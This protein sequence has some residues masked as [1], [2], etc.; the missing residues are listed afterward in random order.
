MITH[1]LK[2]CGDVERKK[3]R[4]WRGESERDG[5]AGR[6]REGG[7]ERGEARWREGVKR[8]GIGRGLRDGEKVV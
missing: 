4:G 5:V 6:E 1:G 2:G 7:S 8:R 3:Y